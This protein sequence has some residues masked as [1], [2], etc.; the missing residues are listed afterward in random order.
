MV[1]ILVISLLMGIALVSY[2]AATNSARAVSDRAMINGLKMAV[3][4]FRTDFG[5]L[6]PMVKDHG[7]GGP[8]QPVTM[9][10]NRV[11][12]LIYSPAIGQDIAVM[13]GESTRNQ[14]A[15]R[16]S[17]YS[18][19]FYLVGA[20][21]A[22]VDGVDGPGFLEVRPTGQFAP[23]P[24][25]E[26]VVGRDG[27]VD[28]A[29][30]GPRAYEPL[31]DVS[32]GNIELWRDTTNRVRFNG[33][34]GVISRNSIIARAE[35]R[36]RNSVPVRYYRWY[37]DEQPVSE[38]PGGLGGYTDTAVDF[39][40]PVSGLIAYLNIPKLVLDAFGDPTDPAYEVPTSLRNAKYAIVGAGPNRLFGDLS[41]AELAAD[42]A[43][44]K[45]YAKY[46]G[47]SETRLRNDSEY[48]EKALVDARADNIVEVG[49]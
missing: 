27:A 35:I 12:A 34:G 38:I 39:D 26:Q 46:L 6:P 1:S 49:S 10:D 7:D 42:D 41:S 14:N 18:L 33:S 21:D 15:Q 13:R 8:D 9:V 44:I 3:E 24:T 2:R 31:F 19:A 11:L 48:R 5:I 16:F 43:A 29:R 45:R 32:R 17:D 47:L 28:V 30:R 23:A 22:P 36:D 4:Q 40:Q 37:P 25:N 20:L